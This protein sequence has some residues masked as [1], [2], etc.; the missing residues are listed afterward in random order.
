[1]A[2][3]IMISTAFSR[4]SPCSTIIRARWLEFYEAVLHEVFAMYRTTLQLDAVKLVAVDLDD[5]LWRGVAAEGTLGV[6]EGWPMGFMETLLY[7]E[8][9][10]HHPGHRQQERRTVHPR[11]LGPHRRRADP[12]ADFAVRKINFPSKAENLAEILREVNLRPQNAVMVDDHPVERAAIQA[13]TARRARAG[14]P[15]LLSQAHPA[16][17]AGNQTPVHHCGSPAARPRWCR[18]SWSARPSAKRCRT[19]NFFKP[20]SCAFRCPASRDLRDVN[21]NRA[22]ELFNK[23]NQFNTTGARY[24]LEQCHRVSGRRP[25]APRRL[26]LRIASRNTG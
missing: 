5:T 21:L 1:M 17:V 20:C 8:K 23:T 15:S 9:A 2:T 3:T 26:K 11:Q 16:V 4:R 19:R 22:L 24:T 6:A 18:R 14:Q 12:L 7:L 13:A 10:R 25:P